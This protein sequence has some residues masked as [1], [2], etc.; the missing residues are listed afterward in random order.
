[1]DNKKER[2]KPIIKWV[3]GKSKLVDTIT[4]YLPNTI[5]TYYEPF[6]GGLALFLSLTNFKSA[7][8]SDINA[9]LI[10]LYNI[11]KSNLPEL[12]REIKSYPINKDTFEMIKGLS[13]YPG[14]HSISAVNKAARFLYLN[15]TCF[16]GLY[17]VNKAGHFNVPFGTPKD[18]TTILDY[19]NAKLVAEKLKL[20]E[21]KCDSYLDLYN[22]DFNKNDLVYFD[23]PYLPI[24]KTASFTNYTNLGFTL[25]DQIKLR[26]LCTYLTKNNVKFIL[27]NSNCDKVKELY[28][29]FDINVIDVYRGL[30]AKANT[31][32]II[33]EVLIKNY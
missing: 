18:S 8:I 1:M 13:R 23:P 19:N 17:R 33:K 10:N 9:E 22:K 4:S 3:G 5:D 27:S 20:A 25:E 28:K 30:S 15:K 21:I 29:D 26:D 7:C 31:R 2:V 32:G 14:Y 24:S 16:N 12:S 6:A 11:V